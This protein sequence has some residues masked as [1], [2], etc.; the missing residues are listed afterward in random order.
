M[1]DPPYYP[2]T[3][4]L[5]ALDSY[6]DENN[7]SNKTYVEL[8]VIQRDPN[9][10]DPAAIQLAHQSELLFSYDSSPTHQQQ[11][12][13]HHLMI[14]G[15]STTT[16]Q[17]PYYHDL[18]DPRNQHIIDL[19]CPSKSY[20]SIKSV[21]LLTDDSQQQHHSLPQMAHHSTDA[22]V[23][24]EPQQTGGSEYSSGPLP[25]WKERALQ[26]ERGTGICMH[27]NLIV[28]LLSRAACSAARCR[29]E[30]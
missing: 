3:V 15:Q 11:Q 5:T 22:R 20:D 1:E 10:Y 7:N 9:P 14:S 25:F 8:E 21:L 29:R 4:N 30:K 16:H 19:D 18:Q 17:N 24:S 13:H 23:K 12:H 6:S 27:H 28:L 2:T 26:I